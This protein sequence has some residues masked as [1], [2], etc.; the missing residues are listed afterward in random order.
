MRATINRDKSRRKDGGGRS[1]DG[2]VKCIGAND[3]DAA[4]ANGQDDG[5]GKIAGPIIQ[6]SEIARALL[7]GNPR[8]KMKRCSQNHRVRELMAAI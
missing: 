6:R 2:S 4:F 7:S 5:G 8:G 1:S 3:K